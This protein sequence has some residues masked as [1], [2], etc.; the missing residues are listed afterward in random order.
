[1][2]ESQNPCLP[3]LLGLEAL[4]SSYLTAAAVGKD[5]IHVKDCIDDHTVTHRRRPYQMIVGM[6]GPSMTGHPV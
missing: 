3:A 6:K 5:V 1:M 4:V 2:K